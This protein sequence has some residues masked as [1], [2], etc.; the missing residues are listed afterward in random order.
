MLRL[1][2][3]TSILFFS[4]NVFTEETNQTQ[5]IQQIS[6]I[7][8]S[9]KSFTGKITGN[10]VRIRTSPDLDSHV[11]CQLNKN[12]LILVTCDSR[13]FWGI[14]PTSNIKAYVFRNYIVDNIVEADKVNIR[15][16]PNMD[17]PIIGQLK[18]KDKVDG[19]ICIQ[20]NKWLEI[21]LPDCINFYIAKEYVSNIGDADYYEKMQNRKTEV[22]KLLNSAYF[23][24]QA[25]CKK[26]YDEM[27][28]QEAIN[29]F[30]SIIKE[31]SDFPQI[32]QQ[33]KE[34]LALLQD[35]YLQ[36]KIAFLE[37][38]ANISTAEKDELLKAVEKAKTLEKEVDLSKKDIASNLPI[39]DKMKFWEPIEN[40]LYS[41]W[42]TFHPEKKKKDFY[43]EQEIN[44]TSISGIV[45][46]YSQSI[47]NKP[48]DYIV[49]LNDS[50][51]AYLYSTKVDL[52]DYVGKKVTL[53]VSPRP[54]NNFAFP[55]YFVN[56]IEVK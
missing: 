24:T 53:K 27:A 31:Y 30:D 34:G 14:K 40:S 50:T 10:K 54:N 16:Q 2:F 42:T 35:N 38:K 22:E 12:D 47:K 26:P 33:A 41:T 4:V 39:S 32:V 7:P 36:K 48:G 28:P 23:I 8:Q 25:E 45:Y 56:S 18:N 20:N 17:S 13:D 29:Q 49:N 1:L 52:K 51:K 44:S 6:Q 15:L 43:K 19:S 5:I 3:V 21:S 11:I 55:A 9:F 46:A 37:A